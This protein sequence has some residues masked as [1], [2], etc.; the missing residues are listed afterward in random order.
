MQRSDLI[1]R[2]QTLTEPTHPERFEHQTDIKALKGIKCVAFDFYGTMFISGAG[3]IG[4]DEEQKASAPK[5]FKEALQSTGFELANA[6]AGKTGLEQFNETIDRVSSEKKDEGILYPEPD[7]ILV[8]QRVL[9]TLVQ[10]NFIEG[11]IT[12]QDAIRFAIEFEFRSNRIWPVPDLEE[13]LCTL[14]E[15]NYSLGIISNSQFYTPLAFEALIGKST[16]AFGFD[17]ALQ[18]WSYMYGIKKPS[19]DF[20]RNFTNE[21]PKKNLEPWEI[22]YV[23]NDLFKDVIPAKKLGMRTALYVGDRRSLRHDDEELANAEQEPDVIID[24][25]HQI[26]RCVE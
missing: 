4:V 5:I 11:P 25:L 3:D 6:S 22:L 26:L 21:L 15:Q 2:I 8:W 23:G 18:K 7:I 19:L 9:A 10:L 14:L 16:D 12:R 24:E 1:E 17:R 20:Y 13:I